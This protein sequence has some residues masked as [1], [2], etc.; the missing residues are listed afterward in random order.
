MLCIVCE[1]ELCDSQTIIFKLCKREV[2]GGNSRLKL[3]SV[4]KHTSSGTIL[5]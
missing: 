5:H 4:E 3:F 2:Q 1:R